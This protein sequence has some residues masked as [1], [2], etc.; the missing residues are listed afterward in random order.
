[1]KKQLNERFQELAGI[2]PLNEASPAGAPAAVVLKGEAKKLDKEFDDILNKSLKD[3]IDYYKLYK[4]YE[5]LKKKLYEEGFMAGLNKGKK[6]STS[7]PAK[8]ARQ[9]DAT[10]REFIRN[11]YKNK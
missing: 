11:I 10:E 8:P 9:L 4:T 1:M 5:K 6:D 3:G 2:K 7:K